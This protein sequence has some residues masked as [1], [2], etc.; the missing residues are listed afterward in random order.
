MRNSI[1]TSAVFPEKFNRKHRAIDMARF[2]IA[3]SIDK[4][5]YP[6]GKRSQY[7]RSQNLFRFSTR[8]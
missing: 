6:N 7:P 4:A 5:L 1:H 2:I 8:A 3:P